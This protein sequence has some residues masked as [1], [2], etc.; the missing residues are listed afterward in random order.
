MT[1][2]GAGVTSGTT[3]LVEVFQAVLASVGV[4][5]EGAERLLDQVM[6]EYR[7]GEGDCTLRFGSHAGEIEIALARGGREFHASC[8]LP[9]R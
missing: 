9:V 6:A 5:G 2:T 3:V 7:K 1:L 8:P 4:T